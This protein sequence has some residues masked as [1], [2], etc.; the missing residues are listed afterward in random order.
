ME[1][2]DYTCILSG[3][4]I[5]E[6][7]TFE[8]ENPDFLD[9][10]LSGKYMKYKTEICFRTQPIAFGRR[11]L[12]VDAWVPVRLLSGR[13]ESMVVNVYGH[14]FLPTTAA[15]ANNDDLDSD[16]NDEGLNTPQLEVVSIFIYPYQY[17]PN[18]VD[19]DLVDPV[20]TIVGSITGKVLPHATRLND[21][22]VDVLT[23]SVVK[24][25]Y[26]HMKVR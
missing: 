17:R 10:M 4:F 14:F 19:Y 22:Y 26:N 2:Y 3:G 6:N 12:D 8:D 9:D 24:G 21:R 7:G 1:S 20:I 13:P 11:R 16:P 23:G 18:E 25:N 5:F 15:L